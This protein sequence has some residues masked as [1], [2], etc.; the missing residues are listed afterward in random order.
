[1]VQHEGCDLHSLRRNHRGQLDR[2][3]RGQWKPSCYGGIGGDLRLR[4]D[5]RCAGSQRN[6]DCDRG[7]DS[8]GRHVDG[9]ADRHHRRE[10]GRPNL[11]FIKCASLRSQWRPDRRRMDRRTLG[12]R[13]G[14]RDAKCGRNDYVCNDMFL[15]TQVRS[16]SRTSRR[17]RPT[18]LQWRRGR[19]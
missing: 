12:Q 1:M 6:G 2:D 17:N 15:R 19:S 13:H 10:A 9:R 4:A 18:R 16:V 7:N 14:E 5:L 11:D 3:D 8:A